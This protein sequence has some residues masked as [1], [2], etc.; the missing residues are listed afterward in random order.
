MFEEFFGGFLALGQIMIP[1]DDYEYSGGFDHQDEDGDSHLPIDALKLG[2]SKVTILSP[3]KTSFHNVA[4]EEVFDLLVRKNIQT[5]LLLY[6]DMG[7]IDFIDTAS[8][9][10]ERKLYTNKE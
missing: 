2:S 7:N 10:K 4:Q 6:H 1:D 3:F 8:L 9:K 5:Y